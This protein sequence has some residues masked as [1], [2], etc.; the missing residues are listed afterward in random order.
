MIT[1]AVEAFKQGKFLDE[2][3]PV[4]KPL[5]DTVSGHLGN[6]Y[7]QELNQFKMELNRKYFGVSDWYEFCIANW[8]TKWD[9]G[10]ED[11]IN[12]TDDGL[13]VDFFDSAWSPPVR[14]YEH[15]VELGFE[16]TAQ[17][18]EPGCAFVGEWIN[19]NDACYEIPGTSDEVKEAIPAHLDGMFAISEWMSENE[20]YDEDDGPLSEEQLK[21]IKEAN[22]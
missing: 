15:L 9:V 2:F 17:Y 6:G 19:G 20:P 13:M 10:D 21:Q 7:E 8:G 4:P 22:E 5:R 3:V 12:T 11:S 16:V 14:V 1:R 18:Y